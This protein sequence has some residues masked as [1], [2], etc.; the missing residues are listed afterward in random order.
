MRCK[1]VCAKRIGRPDVN[2]WSQHDD[3]SVRAGKKFKEVGV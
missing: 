1:K 3:E 2:S